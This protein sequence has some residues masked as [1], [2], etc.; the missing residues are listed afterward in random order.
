VALED[1][2]GRTPGSISVLN[3]AVA[4]SGASGF[5][6]DA[7]G[8]CNHLFDP[9]TGECAAPSRT[10]TVVSESATASDA[11][12]TA[13]ALMQ[14]DAVSSTLARVPGTAVYSVEPGN[15]REIIAHRST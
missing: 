2:S 9:K 8:K 15:L 7:Q 6:F 1:A 11:L 5:R 10:I 14:E 13:F 12:S 4:T 3:K